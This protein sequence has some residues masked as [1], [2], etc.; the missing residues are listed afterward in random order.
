M[1]RQEI[2]TSY[3]IDRRNGTQKNN[4]RSSIY[5]EG[6]TVRKLNTM[7]ERAPREE[8]ERVRERQ[9]RISRS[10][11]ENR[12]RALQMSPGYVLFL[13]AA[14]ALTLGVCAMFIQLQ[15]EISTRMRNVAALESQILDMKT[16]ND[17]T[18]NRIETSVNMEDIKNAAMNELG[19]VYPG[20]DQ[21]VYFEVDAN[22]YMNQYQDIPEK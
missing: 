9:Q 4:G 10:V 18:M 12:R 5:V 13:T 16:D 20:Q 7:P 17:A 21:I 22:D 2:R 19:M 15:S 11:Q 1:A 6:N 14:V 8:R 3:N